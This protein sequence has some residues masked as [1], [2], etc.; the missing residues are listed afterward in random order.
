MI[1]FQRIEVFLQKF[2]NLLCKFSKF[3]AWADDSMN[4]PPN[5]SQ[6]RTVMTSDYIDPVNGVLCY[7]DEAW[8]IVKEE[9]DVKTEIANVGEERARK[10]GVLLDISKDGDFT[11]QLCVPDFKKVRKGLKKHFSKSR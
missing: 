1:I 9:E 7:S 3:R 10:A 2:K 11:Q 5:K 6:G 8:E 4:F